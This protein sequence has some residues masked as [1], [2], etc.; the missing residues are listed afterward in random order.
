MRTLTELLNHS[1]KTRVI[2][3]T[4]TLQAAGW[5]PG[6]LNAIPLT[7]PQIKLY[8][9]DRPTNWAWL[10]SV[11]APFFR[12]AVRHARLHDKD[13]ADIRGIVAYLVAQAATGTPPPTVSGHDWE[14]QLA[15]GLSLYAGTTQTLAAADD[16]QQGGHF[17]VS[18][19]RR[20]GE[21]D[22]KLRPFVLGGPP[23]AVVPADDFCTMVQEVQ[24]MDL[25]R[26]PEWF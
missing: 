8:V 14:H 16:L 6:T 15:L 25:A 7:G 21:R 13:W 26:H 9:W 23:D 4:L 5:T 24:S 3:E 2:L 10:C 11:P 18:N 12:D 19:Y 1:R 20:A 17:C 22:G